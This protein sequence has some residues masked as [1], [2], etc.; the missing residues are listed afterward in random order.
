MLPHLGREVKVQVEARA[1]TDEYRSRLYRTYVSARASELVPPTIEGLQSRAAHLNKLIHCHFPKDR[2]AAI[3]DLGCGHGALIH[4]ARA[5]GYHNMVGIDLST[6]QVDAGRKLG[7][8]NLRQGDLLETISSVADSSIDMVVTFDVIE[9]FHKDELIIFVDEVLRVLRAD[10]RW[11]I[12][13]P[14]GESPFCSR[15]RYG[16]FTHEMAFT[17]E[18]IC[19]LLLSSGFVRVACFED[20]PFA[21]GILSAAR[22]ILWKAIRTALHLRLAIETGDWS[23]G[24]IFSQNFFAIAE[25]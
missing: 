20:G 7:I 6:Q 5:A 21:H 12:H 23:R 22:L 13:A 17:R 15:I 10:G 25:K 16:D 2:N 11:I 1:I 4:S 19:Q 8:E 14:N 9:H 18:S 3:L 24:S